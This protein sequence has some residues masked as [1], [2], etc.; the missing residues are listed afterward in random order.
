MLGCAGL[1]AAHAGA[2]TVTVTAGK[3]GPHALTDW[4]RRCGFRQGDDVVGE[5]RREDEDAL[6]LLGALPVWLDFLDHQYGPSPAE[7]DLATALEAAVAGAD[8]VASPLGLFHEDHVMTAAACFALARTRPAT[9]WVVY[10]DA[11]YRPVV[12]R[13]DAALAT[14]R[15]DG[16]VLTEVDVAEAANKKAAIARYTS[17]VRGLGDLLVDAYRPERYWSLAVR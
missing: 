9:A 3:P 16:F 1:V 8:V 4:D 10:E 7:V 2:L 11:V 14:L 12:G 5:R 15:R 17:Q 13:T 6:A